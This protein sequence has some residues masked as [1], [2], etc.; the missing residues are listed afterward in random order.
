MP[1]TRFFV[2]RMLPSEIPIQ[3]CIGGSLFLGVVLYCHRNYAHLVTIYHQSVHVIHAMQN[4]VQMH[5][6]LTP[7]VTHVICESC[8]CYPITI[9]D[10]AVVVTATGQDASLL[11]NN[12]G[13]PYRNSILVVY[14]N[15]LQDCNS[16]DVL[17]SCT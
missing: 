15:W 11:I 4:G 7:E 16:K 17:L 2:Q 8:N 1:G 3:A 14:S 5:M 13:A 10:V 9:Q 6:S 12:L